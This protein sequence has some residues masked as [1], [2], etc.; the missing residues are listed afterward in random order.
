[1]TFLNATRAV[2]DRR[3][4][5]R[6]VSLMA[7][8][9]AAATITTATAPAAQADQS[10]ASGYVCVWNGEQYTGAKRP[11]GAGSAQQWILFDTTKYSIKNRMVNRAVVTYGSM[12]GWTC[13]N[14]GDQ[15]AGDGRFRADWLYIGAP[16]SHC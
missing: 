13:L 3:M 12:V 7:A 8:S 4:T 2:G 15:R 11:V 9:V 6:L 10:C 5:R 1:M 14:A 16:G